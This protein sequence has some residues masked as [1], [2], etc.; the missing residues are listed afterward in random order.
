[1]ENNLVYAHLVTVDWPIR[2]EIINPCNEIAAPVLMEP[3][4]ITLLRLK[5]IRV[6]DVTESLGMDPEL[7]RKEICYVP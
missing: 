6:F 4:Q 5:G 1:M 3:W 7:V 2:T